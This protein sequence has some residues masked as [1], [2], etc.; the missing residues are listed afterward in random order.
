MASRESGVWKS[1]DGGSIFE[2]MNEGI[3]NSNITAMAIFPTLKD[4]VPTYLLVATEEGGLFTRKL[5]DPEWKEAIHGLKLLTQEEVVSLV[6]NPQDSG[7]KEMFATMSAQEGATEGIGIYQ[8]QFL[9]TFCQ[10]SY[11]D[12]FFKFTVHFIFPLLEPIE[13]VPDQLV[14][15]AGADGIVKSIDKGISWSGLPLETLEPGVTAFAVADSYRTD[16]VHNTF[17]AGLFDQTLF[18]TVDGGQIWTQLDL[19]RLPSKN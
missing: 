4:S 6:I 17:Y 15:Y 16:I 9:G 5:N 8:C 3:T 10:D 1:T 2:E 7:D 14:L 11:P 13:S 18:K 19:N 12:I